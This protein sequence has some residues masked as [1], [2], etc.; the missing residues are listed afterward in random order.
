[1]AR[2]VMTNGGIS[3][4]YAAGAVVL[5]FILGTVLEAGTGK[6]RKTA[7]RTTKKARK[8][9]RKVK[10]AVERKK[11]EALGYVEGQKRKRRAKKR[12][13]LEE[14]KAAIEA[15]LAKLRGN[16]RK[17]LTTRSRRR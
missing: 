17:R 13:A 5:A 8:K 4:Y 6:T 14:R 3:P 7:K 12:S 11:Q 9:V 10:R 15:E 2:K 16:R 1:M